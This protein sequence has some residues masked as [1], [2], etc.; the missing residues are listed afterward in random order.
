[1]LRRQFSVS[2]RNHLKFCTL[3][4]FS[5]Y[6]YFSVRSKGFHDAIIASSEFEFTS[7][8][9]YADRAFGRHRDHCS[10]DCLAASRSTMPPISTISRGIRMDGSAIIRIPM[11]KAD[12]CRSSIVLRSPLKQPAVKLTTLMRSILVHR[13]TGSLM[14]S[15]MAWPATW[16][17]V[18]LTIAQ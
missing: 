12:D 9:V 4:Y 6:F 16:A 17:V 10:S 8:G 18:V 5:R 14:D 15:T 7:V 13:L 11:S 1:M 3:L 2:T